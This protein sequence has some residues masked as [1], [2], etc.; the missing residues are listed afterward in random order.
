M[1]LFILLLF[2]S[3]TFGQEVFKK[4][5]PEDFK[6]IDEKGQEWILLWHDEKETN[7]EIYDEYFYILKVEKDL[8]EPK[9]MH[10]ICPRKEIYDDKRS[11]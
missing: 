9:S 11:I 6:T 3:L 2:T 4:E 5:M 7:G 1:K 8:P 10:I